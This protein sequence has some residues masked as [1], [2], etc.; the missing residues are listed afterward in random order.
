MSS[1]AEV[2]LASS[3]KDGPRL[4]SEACHVPALSSSVLSILSFKRLADIQWPKSEMQ[5]SSRLMVGVMSSRRQCRYNCGS[6]AKA[7]TVT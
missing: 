5:C 7:C 6:S 1:L 2:V 4:P 3:C